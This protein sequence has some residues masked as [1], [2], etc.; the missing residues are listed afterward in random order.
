MKS[1]DDLL[2][3]GILNVGDGI[4]RGHRHGASTGSAGPRIAVVDAI[5]VVD[6]GEGIAITGGGRAAATVVVDAQAIEQLNYGVDVA[7]L[8][9]ADTRTQTIKVRLVE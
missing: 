5:D 6:A 1:I 9:L 8:K 7:L 2:D 3:V 4:G